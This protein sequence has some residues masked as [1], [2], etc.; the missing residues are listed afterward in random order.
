VKDKNI[1]M[2]FYCKVCGKCKTDEGTH[3]NLKIKNNTGYTHDIY[4]L[5]KQQ[6]VYGV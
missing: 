5:V 6:Y 2:P 4:C 3:R 1:E